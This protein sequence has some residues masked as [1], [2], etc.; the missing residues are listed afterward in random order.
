MHYTEIHTGIEQ[1]AK[2]LWFKQFFVG[3]ELMFF[4]HKKCIMG[5]YILALDPIILAP[6]REATFLWFKTIKQF[7]LWLK[8]IT[9]MIYKDVQRQVMQKV[10]DHC[11]F[12]LY[13]SNK[14]TFLKT[15]FPS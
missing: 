5:K 13:I 2:F 10:F 9:V 6:W 1:E 8:V 14:T 3:M 4:V 12:L 15:L 7:Y 11:N